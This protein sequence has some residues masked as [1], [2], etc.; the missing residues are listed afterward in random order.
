[1]QKNDDDNDNE[2]FILAYELMKLIVYN[3]MIN[4]YSHSQGNYIVTFISLALCNYQNLKK[5]ICVVNN[6]LCF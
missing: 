4:Q 6:S 2:C 1:M 3:T 5:M